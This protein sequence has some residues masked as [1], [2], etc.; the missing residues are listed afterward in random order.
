M[1]WKLYYKKAG[2]YKILINN[3]F[4]IGS[5]LDLYTRFKTHEGRFKRNVHENLYM[6]RAYNKYNK[7]FKF[8]VLE[9]FDNIS[10][11]ELLAKE[12][13]YMSKLNP[14]YNLMKTPHTN[15]L[16]LKT[17]LKISKGVKKA[18][19]E[20]RLVNPWGLNGRYI[21]IYD[22]NCNLLY[23]NIL[24][25]DAVLI[26]KISNRSVINNAIRLKRYTIKNYIVIP[27]KENLKILLENSI[28]TKYKKQINLM[29]SCQGIDKSI[30]G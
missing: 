7:N 24:V 28:S 4:Y 3:K 17:K 2:I 11:T 15:T 27:T 12:L 14:H 1:N 16:T 21:D 13:E 25:K 5:S 8:E 23:E 10:Q 19:E 26:L 6:Q 20:G 29:P 30:K 22:Y 18:Y 9:S